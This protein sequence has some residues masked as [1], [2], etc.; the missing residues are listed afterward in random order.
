MAV[1]LLTERRGGGE[2]RMMMTMVPNVTRRMAEPPST[3]G[4][5]KKGGGFVANAVNDALKAPPEIFPTP[6]Y[7]GE[8]LAVS[9]SASFNPPFGTTTVSYRLPYPSPPPPPLN[10]CLTR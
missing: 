4:M 5:H 9:L 1:L 2:V 10:A 6:D 8:P 7:S 3:E